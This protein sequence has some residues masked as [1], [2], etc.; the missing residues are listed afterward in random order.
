[1]VVETH[2][3]GDFHYRLRLRFYSP[4]AA[5]TEVAR[6]FP[7]D[8]K[9]HARGKAIYDLAFIAC[10]DPDGNGVEGACPPINGTGKRRRN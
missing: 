3:D 1:M 9:V 8:G 5:A 10:H 7:I 4:G 6:K 2:L